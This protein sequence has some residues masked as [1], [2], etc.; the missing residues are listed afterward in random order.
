MLELITLLAWLSR[1]R[2][3]RGEYLHAQQY[4][5]QA[6][7]EILRMLRRFAAADGFAKVCLAVPRR[8]LESVAPALAREL[9]AV[10]LGAVP[11]PEARLL[12]IAEQRLRARLP[13]LDWNELV[14]VRTRMLDD[15]NCSDLR[16]RLA[17]S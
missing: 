8:R 16:A 12:E 9:L 5:G 4:L 15:G 2:A 17:R 10:L 14:R 6:I 7:D 13:G 11:S 3:E 1:C